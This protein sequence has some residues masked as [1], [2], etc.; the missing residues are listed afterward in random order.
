MSEETFPTQEEQEE[1]A[2]LVRW[3]DIEDEPELEEDLL[4]EIDELVKAQMEEE[5]GSV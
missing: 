4:A 1:A 3:P 5:D 2:R